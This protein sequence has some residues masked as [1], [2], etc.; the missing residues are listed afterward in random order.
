[1]S[2]LSPGD[3]CFHSEYEDYKQVVIVIKLVQTTF[4]KCFFCLFPCGVID[5]VWSGNLEKLC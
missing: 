2:C 4:G 5:L 3:L 1:M